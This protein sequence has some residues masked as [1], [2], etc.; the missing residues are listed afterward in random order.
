LVVFLWLFGDIS[1]IGLIDFL[2]TADTCVSWAVK[3]LFEYVF[4][5]IDFFLFLVNLFL[6]DEDLLFV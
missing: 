2:F 6:F 5:I 3:V 1:G 4:E